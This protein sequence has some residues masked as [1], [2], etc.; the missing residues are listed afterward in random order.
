MRGV[1]LTHQGTG[2]F[3]PHFKEVKETEGMHL[4]QIEEHTEETRMF[5]NF[6]GGYRKDGTDGSDMEAV[7]DR[8]CS[9]TPLGL[10]SDLLFKVRGF[11]GAWA[12]VHG[13]AL[14]PHPPFCQRADQGGARRQ[15]RRERGAGAARAGLRRGGGAGRGE[16]CSSCR[17]VG[18]GSR[19]RRVAGG[20]V[21]V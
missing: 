21:T 16:S 2:C 3:F 1:K 4:A 13:V 17:S 10:R 7:A 11:P 12:C 15:R 9:V 18:R 6:A 19:R 5:R 8:Y 14:S 20:G